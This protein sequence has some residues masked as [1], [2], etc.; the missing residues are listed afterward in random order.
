MLWISPTVYRPAS[1]VPTGRLPDGLR[2][3]RLR[4]QWGQTG[5][6]VSSSC[7]QYGHIRFASM[8]VPPCGVL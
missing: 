3:V 8:V 4:P 7:I 6:G 1:T 5:S 2:P